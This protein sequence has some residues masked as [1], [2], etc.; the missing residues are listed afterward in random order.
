[1][2][3][4]IILVTGANGGIG[5]EIAKGVAMEKHT[6]IMGCRSL[7]RGDAARRKI[8]EST[9]NSDVHLFL[10]DLAS[11]K[12]IRQFADELGKQ[13][14][15]IDIL[16]NNAGVFTM[17]KGR[18]VDGFEFTMGINFLGT[19]LLTNLLLPHI[20]KADNGRI[21]NVTSDA[22]KMGKASIEDLDTRN[23]TGMRA[24][25]D[26][27]F[28]LMIF[29]LELARRQGDISINAVHPG[30][31]R[32]GIWNFNKWYAFIFNIISRL[33]MISAEEG[34]APVIHAALSV[35]LKGK[36]GRYFNRMNETPVIKI[37]PELSRRLWE[38][39]AGICGF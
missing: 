1:M 31:V 9:G 3:S 24:Y 18:T 8:V 32:S 5:F 21:V 7:E 15:R 17:E 28:A 34:A 30:H 12:S 6:L 26:S 25:S 10:L 38:K 13:F 11:F 22:Y 14:S 2:D 4:S 29:T 33:F 16:I 35:A 19:F 37:D 39:A 20:K 27:K 23:A 36:S